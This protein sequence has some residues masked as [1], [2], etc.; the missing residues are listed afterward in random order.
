MIGGLLGN[1]DQQSCQIL[2]VENEM[3]LLHQVSEVSCQQT[4]TKI[5]LLSAGISKNTGSLSRLFLLQ[6]LQVALQAVIRGRLSLQ[7]G[8]NL[9]DLLRDDVGN[10][11]Q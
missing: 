4:S 6:V 11:A 5:K 1:N 2:R 7:V 3:F 10:V 9:T 8:V